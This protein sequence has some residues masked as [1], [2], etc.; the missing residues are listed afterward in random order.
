MSNVFIRDG[1]LC[2]NGWNVPWP[3]KKRG[4]HRV[5]Q[6]NERLFVDGYEWKN[7]TWKWSLIAFLFY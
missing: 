4:S 7:G 1:C 6:R 3:S 5:S 2:V